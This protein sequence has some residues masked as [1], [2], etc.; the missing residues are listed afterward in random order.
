MKFIDTHTHLYAEEFD[1]DY[2]EVIQR[3][4][5]N[6][7]DHLLLPA[8]DIS[9]YKRMMSVVDSHPAVCLPMT[10]LHPTSVKG[11]FREELEFVKG[12]LK[13]NRERF[14][15]IGEIGIDL[16]WDRTF[17]KEQ[18]EAFNEQLDLAVE[19]RLPVAIHT[20]NSFEPA[21]EILRK[22]NNPELKGVFHCFSG[23]VE[24]ARQATA[25][26]FLLGIGGII[27]F[28]NSGLQKVVESTPIEYLL[29]ETDA[30]YLAPVPYRGKRNESSY[31]PIIAAKI[32]GIKEISVEEVAR[33]T[34]ANAVSLFK[35]QPT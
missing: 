8:I 23:S 29:L 24:Q 9:Y 26:G 2:P 32:A 34:T 27:T 25:L 7:V 19:Y 1:P 20:R 15:A 33:I 6:G 17:E 22:K 30:P 16:Y 3:S 28:K 12:T 35:L 21:M 13:G 10:G 18:F 14:Y 4:I 31:I 5:A 11:N